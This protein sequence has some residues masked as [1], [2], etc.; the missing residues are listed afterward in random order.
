VEAVEETAKKVEEGREA[1]SAR[2][3]RIKVNPE[4]EALLPKLPKEEYEALKE[5]IRKNGL[6][7]PITVNPDGVILDGHHRYRAC[8]EL[9]V[10]P[11]VEIL[12][13]GDP[14]LEKRYVV[15]ANLVRRH[16]TTFQKVEMALPLIEIERELARRR[17]LRGDPR[18]KFAEGKATE[19]VGRK[20][21]VSHEIVRQALWLIEN[22]PREEVEKLRRGERAISNLYRETRRWKAIQELRERAKHLEP[23]EGEYNVI[24]VDP[25]WPYGT[26]YDPE[27]RRCAS[28]YPEM[29]LEEI[30]RLRIPAAEDCV[31]WLWT[32][33]HFMHEAFHILE[34]W[35]FE[36]K[37]ILTWVK[38]RMGL[39]DWLRGQTEHSIM[40][41]RGK[42]VINLTS[43]STV[44][45]GKAREHSRKPEEFYSLVESLCHGRKLDYFARTE[46][47]GWDTYGTKELSSA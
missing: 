28:P 37:A 8:Q 23:P 22:A 39:G 46:R 3:V 19:V 34:A 25:P 13:L 6:Y 12:D 5:S 32:T 20:I 42:P 38:D 18:Q 35:G 16:L 1:R 4:Y 33:N 2:G 15:E 27:G 29:S 44:L 26:R 30:E 47:E 41:V 21:G 11:R 10:K 45:Y 36:P 9:G 43:Q 40:A 31:L 24:V 7:N 14:L 17:M